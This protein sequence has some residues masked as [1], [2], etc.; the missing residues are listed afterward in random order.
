VKVVLAGGSG[1]L[2]RRI[3][4]AFSSDGHD[5]VILTRRPQGREVREVVW[6]GRSV[7]DW[8][9][10]IEGAVV[11]NLAGE[12]VDRRA[13]PEG[14]ALLT[15][16]RVEP[17]R[18]IAQA[19]KL[20]S[21]PPVV[22]VQASTTA[23]YGD[24]GDAILDESAPVAEG[25]PQMA[26]VARA[27]EDAAREVRADR[28]VVLRTAIV[29]DTGTPALDRLVTLTRFGLGGRIASGRQWVSWI[30]I[31]DFLRIVQRAVDDPS[32]DGVVHVSSPYP[33]T[34]R[35]LMRSLRHA[36]HRPPSPPTPA[37]LV[38]VGAMFM[39]TDPALALLGRRAVPRKLLDA[40]FSFEFPRLDDAL[41]DLLR[42]T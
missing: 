37:A 20:A 17:T 22:L 30:H 10:E 40:G 4:A 42:P 14:I 33:V 13:T 15:A 41:D 2:G 26:G 39:R 31:A 16:S 24:A 6:D 5:V 27:W 28:T 38:R 9:A 29:L 36:L 11:V 7:G 12:L 21:T 34:N 8:A 18:A 32:L 25:P 1:S 23:I 3:A 35:E 19:S